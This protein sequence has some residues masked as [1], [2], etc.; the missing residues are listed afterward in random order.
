MQLRDYQ[1]KIYEGSRASYRAGFKAP[2]VCSPTG[3][4]K[5]VIT[6]SM[7]QGSVNRGNRTWIVAHRKELLTQSSSTLKKFA[8]PHG[9]IKAGMAPDY[10]A[11]VQVCSIQSLASRMKY[12]DAPDLIII[13]EC[14]HAISGNYRKIIDAHPNARLL[15]FTATPERLD[16]R[17]LGDVFDD[18]VMGPSVLELMADGHL[19]YARYYAP[20][21]KVDLSNVKRRMGDFVN[22]QLAEA[23]NR[24]TIT[25]DAVA[26]YQKY[27]DGVPM[28][29][30]CVSVQHAI[31]VAQAY[32][33]AGYTAS[34]I[35]GSM[36]DADRDDRLGGLAS[37]RY[38]II[39]SCDLV[40]EGL[41]VPIV[42]AAQL[43]RPTASLILHLQQIGRVLRPA[44]G[45][46]H[47]VIL[48]HVGNVHRHGFA[49]SDRHWSLE[50]KPKS[51][52]N[53]EAVAVASCLN[54]FAAHPPA[55]VCPYCG[56]VYPAPQER[57]GPDEEEGSLEE[58]DPKE[59]IRKA[60]R[61]EGQCK[62]FDDFVALGK[63]RNYKN[64]RGWARHRARARGMHY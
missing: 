1:L 60:R 4:G 50:S 56:F 55:S 15:G 64:P 34:S 53:V 7:A 20:P 8:I 57:T 35:D 9:L 52:R 14:H 28:L 54:C 44:P 17:G 32:R 18:I 43:L 39:T 6:A 25:G 29:V 22:S 30:F 16:G 27:C 46:E 48:D 41:D 23:V 13:D 21:P 40:G 2:L 62:S 24:P 63:S 3:S 37:G 10:G 51:Q 31:D 11:P 61:E 36:S 26:H 38:K 5:T 49:E 47:A 59:R 12:L 19:S 58:L 42:T 45:K 33:E